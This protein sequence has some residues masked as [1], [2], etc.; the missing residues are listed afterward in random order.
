MGQRVK[1]Y[2]AR[3]GVSQ[4][5][6][7]WQVQTQPTTVS[8]WERGETEP[9]GVIRERVEKMLTSPPPA[10][11]MAFNDPM[12]RLLTEKWLALTDVE[13]AEALL[14]VVELASKK[15]HPA[16]PAPEPESKDEQST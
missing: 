16:K 11:I 7:A 5:L 4:L 9:V 2:R 3:Y 1:D 13:K 12:L 15:E 10:E 8:R 14:R 6:V